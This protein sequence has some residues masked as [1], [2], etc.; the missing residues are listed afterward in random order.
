MRFY[1][2]NLQLNRIAKALSP[3]MDLRP[4]YPELSAKHEN[5]N[6][7]YLLKKYKSGPYFPNFPNLCIVMSKF[8]TSAEYFNT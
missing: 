3:Y 7:L 4:F 5:S 2:I 8:T 1:Q 6:G